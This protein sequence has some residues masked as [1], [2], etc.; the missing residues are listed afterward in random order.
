MTG[1]YE[2]D[3][4]LLELKMIREQLQDI[5]KSKKIMGGLLKGGK[6]YVEIPIQGEWGKKAKKFAKMAGFKIKNNDVILSA[7]GEP[8][9]VII[10]LKTKITN[11]VK[12]VEKY[13]KKNK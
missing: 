6:V 10:G 11:Y 13:F 5:F 9:E 7:E 8:A 4:F 12:M 2:L 3:Q 1:I